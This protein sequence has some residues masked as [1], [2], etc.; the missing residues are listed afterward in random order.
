MIDSVEILKLNCHE[1]INSHLIQIGKC[2]IICDLPLN[3]DAILKFRKC[4]SQSLREIKIENFYETDDM[5]EKLVIDIKKIPVKIDFILISNVESFVGLPIFCKYFDLSITQIVCTK[6][7]YYFALCVIQN[8][9]KRETYLPLW[10]EDEKVEENT[11]SENEYNYYNFDVSLRKNMHILSFKEKVNFVFKD[12]DLEISCYS[13]GYALGSCN[14]YIKSNFISVLVISKSCLNC[15]RYPSPFDMDCFGN[16]DVVLFTAYTPHWAKWAYDIKGEEMTRNRKQEKEEDKKEAKVGAKETKEKV[17]VEEKKQ[18]DEA[19]EKEQKEQKDEVTQKEQKDG[20]EKEEQRNEV[21][22]EEQTNEIEAKEQKDA[23]EKKEQKNHS[24]EIEKNDETKEQ[25]QQN[26]RQKQDGDNEV[27]ET[28][29]PRK[30]ENYIKKEEEEKTHHDARNTEKREKK[31]ENSDRINKEDYRSKGHSKVD[32]ML[33]KTRQKIQTLIGT[34]YKDSVRKL[35]AAII[36]AIKKK[37]CVLIPMD[38]YYLYFIEL[39]E[40]IGVAISKYVNVEDQVTIFTV[41]P[42]INDAIYYAE[43][44]ADWVDDYRKEKCCRTKYPEHPFSFSMMKRN[45]RLFVG[46]SVQNIASVFKSPCVCF[47]QDSSLRLFE[48]SDVFKKW[49]NDEKNTII[50]VDAAYDPLKLLQPFNILKAKINIYFCPILWQL[51]EFDI[52]EVMYRNPCQTCEYIIPQELQW[53]LEN[54]N[55]TDLTM[56][57]QNADDN[58]DRVNNHNNANGSNVDNYMWKQEEAVITTTEF[59]KKLKTTPIDTFMKK[60]VVLDIPHGG[61]NI[62]QGSNIPEEKTE[63]EIEEEEEQYID[64][65]EEESE[66]QEIDLNRINYICPLKSVKIQYDDFAELKENLIPMRFFCDSK[67][68]LEKKLNKAE[69]MYFA[70]VQCQLTSSFIGD[71]L[72]AE[73]VHMA[74]E[75]E[76]RGGNTATQQTQHKPEGKEEKTHIEEANT[77]KKKNDEEDQSIKETTT[78]TTADAVTA[79]ATTKENVVQEET[80]ELQNDDTQEEQSELLKNETSESENSDNMDTNVLLHGTLKAV[81]VQKHFLTKGYQAEDIEIFYEDMENLIPWRIRIKP[82]NGEIICD[83]A[84]NVEVYTSND[85]LRQNVTEMIFQLMDKY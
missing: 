5:S 73:D 16:A 43:S 55:L 17:E 32:E 60:N 47:M 2:N 3:P 80:T 36:C 7:T 39:T 28:S 25:R 6:P 77:E 34:D 12:M 57:F 83:S 44:C 21:E 10:E 33:K 68:E 20:V 53:F 22:K 69:D 61:S 58:D 71:L 4:A 26:Q 41:M 75:T 63:E 81:D 9:Q 56:Y 66:I 23:V 62:P 27:E 37:G 19:A 24:E 70:E 15:R 54:A 29:E 1:N 72:N 8:L 65:N 40:V 78:A 13:S 30:H 42:N 46:E 31:K 51:N 14:F 18:K 45:N 79:I 84:N 67:T 85:M 59:A 76:K 82:L 50:L 49:M 48:S 38:L 74:A 35:C 52:L 64:N 11:Q